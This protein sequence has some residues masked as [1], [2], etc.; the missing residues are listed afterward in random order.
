MASFVEEG[1]R[2][3]PHKV[4]DY[5]IKYKVSSST[6][7]PYFKLQGTSLSSPVDPSNQT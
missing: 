6:A 5:T 3:N 7:V 2:D 4:F 1:Y